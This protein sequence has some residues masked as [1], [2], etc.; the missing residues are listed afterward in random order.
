M[1]TP[2]GERLH[3]IILGK[4]NSG[5]SAVLNSI[6][7]Q[8]ISIS[9]EVPGTTTD[10]VEK[11]M[12]IHGLG[13]VLFIDTAGFDD[14]GDLGKLRIKKTMD[15]I[16]RADLALMVYGEDSDLKEDESFIRI[17]KELEEKQLPIINIL[18]KAD[19]ID[20]IVLNKKLENPVLYST[21]SGKGREKLLEILSDFRK[22][23]RKDYIV[24]NLVK[25]GDTV[26]LVM[27]QDKQAPEGRLILPQVQVIREL[28]DRRISLMCTTD[29]TFIEDTE[30]LKK[31]PE[32]IITDS[33]VFNKIYASLPEESMLTS[34]S[35]L[36]AA[37]KGDI[38]Y[39]F[40][41]AEHL[42]NLTEKSRILIAEA[43]THAP[44]EEDI[45]RV[46]I[47]NLLKKKLGN[48]ID[49]D[50]VS[51]KDFPKDLSKYDLIIHCG[52]CMFNKSHV[53]SRVEEA[54]K[55]NIKMSNYG[56][57]IAKLTG[58][59]DKVSIPGKR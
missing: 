49:I 35:V 19:E 2:A 6:T 13:P 16:K 4:R 29:E 45:G 28:I 39:F 53:S 27:P 43:C 11:A 31:P 26:V 25:K 46:K 42:D 40:E 30:K 50:M 17:L 15:A 56:L 5:K 55:Q 12:E 23:I 48:S 57:I 59:L 54:K 22:N 38:N 47:P 1:K 8:D 41:G 36:F 18:N 37:Y 52:A 21:E 9:S 7:G 58:I 33:Q 51:G 3:I 32:L 44:I 24:G 10:P 20:Y 34:F 14:V